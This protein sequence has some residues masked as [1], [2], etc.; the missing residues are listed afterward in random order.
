MGQT[1]QQL[2]NLNN[3][4]LTIAAVVSGNSSTQWPTP[5]A[6]SNGFN[7]NDS[8]DS[9]VLQQPQNS[10]YRSYSNTTKWGQ[11]VNYKKIFILLNTN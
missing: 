1:N 2:N 9:I 4:P 6:S 11:N 5:D 7:S 8:I 10:N 3:E